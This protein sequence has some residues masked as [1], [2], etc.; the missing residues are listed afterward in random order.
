MNIIIGLALI[1]GRELRAV[2]II[3]SHQ[4]YNDTDTMNDIIGI[5]F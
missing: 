4:N 3:S 1:L 2:H 5:T